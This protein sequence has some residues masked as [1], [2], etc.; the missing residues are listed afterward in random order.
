MYV[1]A[2]HPNDK[3]VTERR[4][5]RFYVSCPYSRPLVRRFTADLDRCQVP[6][7]LAVRPCSKNENV[8]MKSG[9]DRRTTGSFKNSVFRLVCETCDFQHTYTTAQF[10]FKRTTD[11][12][13]K[14]SHSL[15][16]QHLEQNPDHRMKAPI[17][18]KVYHRERDIYYVQSALPYIEASIFPTALSNIGNKRGCPK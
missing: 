5:K 1:C 3:R 17:V 14:S 13:F 16:R 11:A 15:V 6:M 9:K 8:L 4:I 2:P 18:L 12:I 10:D 7:K